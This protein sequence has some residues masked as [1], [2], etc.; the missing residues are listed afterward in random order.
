MR[1]ID[2]DSVSLFVEDI[3]L[4]AVLAGPFVGISLATI[5]AVVSFLIG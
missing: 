3:S 1:A 2:W 4:V 5:Y